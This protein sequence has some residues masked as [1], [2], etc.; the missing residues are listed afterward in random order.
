MH[1]PFSLS[2]SSSDEILTPNSESPSLIANYSKS[3][4]SSLT[5]NYYA[6]H[7]VRSPRQSAN[8]NFNFRH[9]GVISRLSSSPT[10][11]T[12]SSSPSNENRKFAQ[13][14][15]DARTL[16][17][18][19]S[20]PNEDPNHS[21]IPMVPVRP[22]QLDSRPSSLSPFSMIHIH[23]ESHFLEMLLESPNL[24]EDIAPLIRQ[25][26]QYLIHEDDARKLKRMSVFS[27]ALKRLPAI[28]LTMILEMGVG[29]VVSTF[30]DL[31]KLH[32]ALVSFMPLISSICGT[33]KIKLIKIKIKTYRG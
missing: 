30:S 22:F 13:V 14:S 1:E 33:I 24:P 29:L 6:S 19:S 5:S 27:V 17:Y 2:R 25:R 10:F 3:P 12:H 8:D 9:S 18:T 31:L 4:P 7:S 28:F 23:S 21:S 32:V 11:S 16:H 15:D 20:I 26:I